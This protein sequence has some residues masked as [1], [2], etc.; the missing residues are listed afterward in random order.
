MLPSWATDTVIRIRPGT[1]ERRGSIEPDWS[2]P[3]ELEIEG[4]SIQP[5]GTTLSQDGRVL[6]VFDG[7]SCFFPPGTD[8]VAGDKIRFNGKDYQ[9]IGEPRDWTSPTGLV[10]S[11][12]AQMERW[13]G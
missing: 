4:C 8:V 5:A 1:I 3:L 12:Q 13:S 2:N 9:I 6:G 10:S 7:Y 11:L